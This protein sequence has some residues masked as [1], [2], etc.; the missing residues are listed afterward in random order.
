MASLC[1]AYVPIASAA[2]PPHAMGRATTKWWRGYLGGTKRP[3]RHV[4]YAA[5]PPLHFMGRKASPPQL[6]S[7]LPPLVP[8][9]A[10]QV[11]RHLVEGRRRPPRS[12][13]GRAQPLGQLLR[14]P[15][16]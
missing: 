4:G 1:S 11:E 3:L 2:F 9:L 6:L 16:V 8:R 15:V 13:V 14:R 5:A 10:P 7:V 12:A